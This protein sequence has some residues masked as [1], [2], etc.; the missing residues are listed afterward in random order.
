MVIAAMVLEVPGPGRAL[1]VGT[2]VVATAV[3]VVMV[4]FDYLG[5][6]PTANAAA[7]VRLALHGRYA[8]TFWGGGSRWRCSPWRWPCS[9]GPARSP[10]PLP[11][12]CWCSWRSWPTRA[13]S[14]VLGKTFRCPNDL[15]GDG[16]EADER[17][18]PGCANP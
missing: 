11:Q 12:G 1:L 5:A 18:T 13:S 6:H 15:P 3:H 4:L 9:G 14:S 7:A 16:K 8:P 2:L 10:R 17:A